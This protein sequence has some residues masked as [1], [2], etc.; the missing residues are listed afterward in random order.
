MRKL[1]V[2]LKTGKNKIYLDGFV[3][4]KPNSKMRI[5]NASV[6]WNYQNITGSSNDYYVTAVPKTIAFENGYWTFRMLADRFVENNVKLVR[7]N[8]SGK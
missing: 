2:F 8:I 3:N 7:N 1:S 4:T 5:K 6:Y